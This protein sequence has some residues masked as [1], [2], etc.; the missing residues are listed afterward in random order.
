MTSLITPLTLLV[1]VSLID[2]VQ[3]I[4]KC[5]A[6]ERINAE[7]EA[8][9]GGF[10]IPRQDSCCMWDVCGLACPAEV[11]EPNSGRSFLCVYPCL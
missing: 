10:E 7:F 4:P 3:A 8:L 11:E 1:F 2:K 5:I 6:D 9:T